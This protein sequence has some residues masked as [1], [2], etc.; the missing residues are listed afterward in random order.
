MHLNTQK[1]VEP[2]TFSSEYGFIAKFC[3]LGR[4]VEYI[5]SFCFS[6]YCALDGA[7]AK[8]YGV[9]PITVFDVLSIDEISKYCIES[10]FS[11]TFP[12]R[13][14]FLSITSP[15]VLTGYPFP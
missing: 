4:T 6:T 8:A 2:T 12:T 5:I 7:S 10:V 15:I 13:I 3:R 9:R 14:I 1:P 11:N